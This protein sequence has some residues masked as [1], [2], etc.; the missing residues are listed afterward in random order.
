MDQEEWARKLLQK[1]RQTAD[2]GRKKKKKKK[3][4]EEVRRKKQVKGWTGRM[5]DTGEGWRKSKYL[6]SLQV[7]STGIVP[8]QLYCK[9]D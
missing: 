9:S 3:K 2:D 8:V 1:Q 7:Y 4:Y 5:G 6:Y